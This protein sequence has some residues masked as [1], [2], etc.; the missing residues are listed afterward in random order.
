MEIISLKIVTEIWLKILAMDNMPGVSHLGT[1]NILLGT[2]W[3][4]PPPHLVP[5]FK[6]THQHSPGQS[7]SLDLSWL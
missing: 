7:P 6:A 5:S 2:N 3:P 1:Y 4:P